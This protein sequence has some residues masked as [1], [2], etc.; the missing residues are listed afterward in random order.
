VAVVLNTVG[1]F[2]LGG[3]SPGGSAGGQQVVAY[4]ASH[5]ADN[6]RW[7]ILVA[8]TLLFFLVFVGFL[9]GYLRRV[10]HVELLSSLA[11]AGAVLFATGFAASASL[12]ATLADSPKSLQPA[13]AQALNA[14]NNGPIYAANVGSCVFAVAAG[15][16]IILGASL[17]RWLGWVA[18]VLGLASL[19]PWAEFAYNTLLL[20][21][22]VTAVA[23]YRRE[24]TAAPDAV[25]ITQLA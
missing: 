6:Q 19:T 16:A 7:A 13:A 2:V 21:A 23:L 20:W 24:R 14:L 9:R 3:S 22:F 5:K 8:G 12:A 11:L 4:F 17:P 25:T 1:A 15:I 10:P 18:V